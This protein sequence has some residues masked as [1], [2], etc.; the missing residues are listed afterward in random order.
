MTIACGRPF[1]GQVFSIKQRIKSA[2]KRHFRAVRFSDAEFP[3]NGKQW[4]NMPNAS[5]LED[6][7]SSD[8]IPR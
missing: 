4:Q 1:S 7:S 8:I 6:S 5:K 2:Y 3:T